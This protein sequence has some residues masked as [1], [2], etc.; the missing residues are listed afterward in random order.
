MGEVKVTFPSHAAQIFYHFT[1]NL[2]FITTDHEVLSNTPRPHSSVPDPSLHGIQRHPPLL[3]HRP[4]EASITD[5]GIVTCWIST[6]LVEHDTMQDALFS[7][8]HSHSGSGIRK[9]S[10]G[11]KIK[12]TD[13]P[14]YDPS[15]S[16]SAGSAVK[17]QD[18]NP[19]SNTN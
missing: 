1:K 7:H 4:F 3:P 13:M 15:A 9:R 18:G 19:Q 2:S 10:N 5:N 14:A 8:Q 6:S 11:R 16:A 17:Q 12:L